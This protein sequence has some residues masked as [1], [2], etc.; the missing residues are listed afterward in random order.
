VDAPPDTCPV[1][2]KPLMGRDRFEGKCAS[3]R[4][5]EILAELPLAPDLQTAPIPKSRPAEPEPAPREPR[6]WGLP[7]LILILVLAAAVGG[8][9]ALLVPHFF[10][11]PPARPTPKAAHI[12][13]SPAPAPSPA[14]LP[15]GAVAREPAHVPPAEP[16][17][18]TEVRLVTRQFLEL[19][20]KGDYERIIDNYCQPDETAFGRVG[21][22]VTAF[23]TGP[24][25]AGF[26]A[27]SVLTVR[28]GRDALVQRLRAAGDPH[29][30]YTADLLAWLTRSPEASNPGRSA[31][32][33]ARAVYA[34]H[35]RGLYG[36]PGAQEAITSVRQDGRRAALAELSSGKASESPRPGDA[37]NHVRWQRLPVGW[38]VR[39]ALPERM[40][41]VRDV[42]IQPVP[43]K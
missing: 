38:V 14:P 24:G 18:E 30:D 8:T 40:E 21:R 37:R 20:R 2:G 28:Q 6:R 29:P 42:L 39:L 27:W 43:P 31:E 17:D 10:P 32:D 34:W 25:A 26:G 23:V 22:A 1:C 41:D 7:I 13:D 19:L 12:A 33:R 4:E 11:P 9:A 5:E 35:L 15:A 3:C 36:V 16:L